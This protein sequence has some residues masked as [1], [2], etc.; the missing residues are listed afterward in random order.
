[1][2]L[3]LSLFH[4]HLVL[5][6]HCKQ[7][8]H[9]KTVKNK[10]TNNEHQKVMVRLHWLSESESKRPTPC[11]ETCSGDVMAK[12]KVSAFKVRKW[13]K[14]QHFFT[15]QEKENKKQN[16]T[17]QKQF[18]TRFTR[19]VYIILEQKRFQKNEQ[20]KRQNTDKRTDKNIT[21]LI[22]VFDNWGLFTMS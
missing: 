15:R 7:V 17:K 19:V 11:H 1:M 6:V 16:K 20:V 4:H 14:F 8:T 3:W 22:N 2:L 5:F 9:H 10:Q 21:E 13:K 18:W 12:E